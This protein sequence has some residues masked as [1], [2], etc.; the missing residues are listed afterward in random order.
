MPQSG[1]P[2]IDADRL[3]RRTMGDEALQ[4]EVLALFAAEVERLMRQVASAADPQV[5]GDRLQAIAVLARNTGALH[6]AQVARALETQIVAEELDLE[7][8]REAVSETLAYLG[9][10]GA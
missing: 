7:P 9:N 1:L 3:A 10:A 8:L 4:V 2:V 5:R 6:L